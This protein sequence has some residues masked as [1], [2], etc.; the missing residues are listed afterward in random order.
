MNPDYAQKPLPKVVGSGFEAHLAAETGV[1]DPHAN[2]LIC[3]MVVYHPS[4]RINLYRAMCSPF[5]D[6]LR[7]K[8]VMLPNGNCMPDLFGFSEKEKAKMGPDCADVLIPSWYDPFNS[9]CQHVVA[10]P[11]V[12]H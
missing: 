7:V 2:D 11:G 9:P 3:Q 10:E 8:D 5:F 6:E 4:K 12:I 1:V